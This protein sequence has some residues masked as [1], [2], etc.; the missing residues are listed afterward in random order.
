MSILNTVPLFLCWAVTIHKRHSMT[1]SEIV[2]DKSREK[3]ETVKVKLMLHS[4]VQLN[5]TNY[6]LL[7]TTKNR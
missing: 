7:I 4:A 3:G 5:W 1:L 2:V 6:I